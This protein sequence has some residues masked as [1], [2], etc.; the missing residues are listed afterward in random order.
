MMS[1]N[2]GSSFQGEWIVTAGKPMVGSLTFHALLGLKLKL[3]T[4]F[5]CFVSPPSPGHYMRLCF[6]PFQIS[7]VQI[8]P[9]HDVVVN[10]GNFVSILFLQNSG[11]QILK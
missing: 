11:L 2:T 8:Y 9:A 4:V 5:P 3:P 1:L 10:T 7:M 6:I